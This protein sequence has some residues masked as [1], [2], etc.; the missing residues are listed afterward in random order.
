MPRRNVLITPTC[1]KCGGVIPGDDVNVAND[2]AFC[3]SCNVAQ[4]LSALL[5]DA[6]IEQGV[7]LNRP[8]PG[9]WRHSDGSGAVTGATHRS[10]GTAV[11]LLAIS[12]FWNGIVSVFVLVAAS[13]T[14]HNLGIS[15]PSWFP[16]PVMNDSPMSAGMT[17]FLWLFLTPFIVIGTVMI[18]AFLSALFGR[19]EMR[20]SG[21]EAVVFVGIGPLG[22]RRRFDPHS[23][24][25]VSIE[26]GEV[27]SSQ[28]NA[29]EYI[30]VETKEGKRIKFG[31]SLPEERRKF[32]AA[33]VRNDIA[34]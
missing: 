25:R 30:I 12:L 1:P 7:D 16:A 2:V 4:P 14:L 20:I 9:V 26:R 3:R 5:R 29:K 24:R 22:Y 19:T 31:T 34:R 32:L 11:G 27:R 21:S 17:I 33:A 15:V 13:A 18:T 10:L 28:G 6:E 8:P 23:V